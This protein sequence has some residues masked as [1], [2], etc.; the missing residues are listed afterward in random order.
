MEIILV[1]LNVTLA[2]VVVSFFLIQRKNINIMGII[3]DILKSPT[4]RQMNYRD[5]YTRELNQQNQALMQIGIER[6][7]EIQTFRTDIKECIERNTVLNN[8]VSDLKREEI[9]LKK[10]NARLH[11]IIEAYQNKIKKGDL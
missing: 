11:V 1:C 6:L 4:Y 7:N 8:E 2:S 9:L 5:E 3:A 10:E